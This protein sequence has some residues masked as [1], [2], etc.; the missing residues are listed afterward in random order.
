MLP[1]RGEACQWNDLHWV[2]LLTAAV[3]IQ[4]VVE[5]WSVEPFVQFISF[6][7]RSTQSVPA[8]HDP[9]ATYVSFYSLEAKGGERSS[10]GGGGRGRGGAVAARALELGQG[11]GHP[12]AVRVAQY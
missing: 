2:F 10:D 5:L 8:I 11:R 6:G 3:S 4:G 7:H 1:R 9:H 12:A